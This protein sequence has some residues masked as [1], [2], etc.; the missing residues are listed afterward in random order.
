[1][2]E[3]KEVWYLFNDGTYSPYMNMAIDELLLTES[4]KIN[5]PILRFYF[6]DRPSVS[7]GYIQ[8]YIAAPQEGYSIVRRPTGGGVVFHDI[9]FT[10]TVVVP[11]GH[12]IE[13]LNRVE[14]Y[15]IFHKAVIKALFGMGIKS[16]VVDFET[17]PKDRMTMQCFVAPTKYDVGLDKK[18]DSS[19][20]AGAAQRRTKNGILHQ[21][22]IV[23]DGIHGRENKLVLELTNAFEDEFNIKYEKFTPHSDF[24]KEAK[25]LSINKY[26]TEKWNNIR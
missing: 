25:E 13:K 10:Y 9:D 22:S 7:I 8:K 12:W 3:E 21:G 1:M 5:A 2:N 4:K 19:K 17:K 26:E 15:H 18:D 11:T 24:M 20:I 16:S 23:I 14:S 6:W